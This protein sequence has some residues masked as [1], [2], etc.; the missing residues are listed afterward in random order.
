MAVRPVE[1]DARHLDWSAV[2]ERGASLWP[3]KS[4]HRDQRR[5]IPR[6]WR[7]LHRETIYSRVFKRGLDLVVGLVGIALLLLVI[8]V[9]AAVVRL[10]SQGPVFF[11]QTRI[12]RYGKPFKIWKFRTMTHA[13][14][15]EFRLFHGEDGQYRH[16]IPDDPRVTRIGRILRRTSL[17]ETPQIINVLRG[18][19]SLVG[20]RPELPQIVQ[21][22]QVWQHQ[23]H[24]VRPGL[25]GWWQV[26]GRGD[27]PMH[28]HTEFDIY[29]LENL[30]WRLDAIILWRT[31][32][33]VLRQAG[34]F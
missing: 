22:Y 21:N 17:D 23:R 29:Y 34:A 6:S 28:E 13:P 26:N 5:S 8:P 1:E 2:F 4:E 20:P 25:T 11:R 14:N 19:M 16:K 27:R 10:D 32:R 7:G 33:F 12:G 15:D 31:I 24:A 9:V 30:S 3:E 18:D